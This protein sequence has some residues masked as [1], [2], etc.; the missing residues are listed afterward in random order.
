MSW[1]TIQVRLG[2]EAAKKISV[3]IGISKGRTT[4]YVRIGVEAAQTLKFSH[5]DM[6]GIDWGDGEHAGKL[7]IAKNPDDGFKAVHKGSKALVIRSG[8]VP[9]T[10]RHEKVLS[11]KCHW[12]EDEGAAIIELDPSLTS[13]TQ[14]KSTPAAKGKQVVPVTPVTDPEQTLANAGGR[15]ED[16]KLKGRRP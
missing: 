2:A 12:T 9:P 15:F 13:P 14:P 16:A 6:I 1:N 3:G 10:M 5:D 8:I 11:V 4:L 7:R